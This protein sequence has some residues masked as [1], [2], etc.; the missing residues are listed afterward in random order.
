V[1][2]ITEE[3]IP[4]GLQQETGRE[5]FAGAGQVAMNVVMD[6]KGAVHRRPGISAFFASADRVVDETGISAVHQASNGQVYAVGNGPNVKAIYRV[7]PLG[8]S[9]LSH[10]MVA[11]ERPVIAETQSLLVLAGGQQL[12]KVTL[13]NGLGAFL[14]GSP[15]HSTHVA[16][17]ASR[18]VA[19][20]VSNQDLKNNFN[21]S[22]PQA[23]SGIAGYETWNG[24]GDSGTFPANA[25]PDA[26][27]GVYEK[28]NEL[29]IFGESNLQTFSPDPQT[30]WA[31]TA[32]REFGC[33]APYSVIKDDQ[34]FAWLDDK[35]RFVHSDGRTFQVISDAIKR[36]L[37]DMA[38]V[39]DCFGYRIVTGVTDVLVWTFPTDGRTFVFSKQSGWSQWSG[40]NQGWQP[41]SV[42]AMSN[43]LG[44]NRNLVGLLDGRMGIMNGEAT[45]DLGAEINA[46]M[47]TGFLDHGTQTRK[48]CRRVR[49]VLRKPVGTGQ[50]ARLSWRDDSGPW[51]QPL[52]ARLEDPNVVQFHSL[53]VYRQ[54]QW[55][56]EFMGTAEVVLA[57][58]I[59][60]F[61]VLNG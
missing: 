20:E 39:D 8:V 52:Y 45:T 55:R 29:F 16:A 7:T 42:L 9:R 14:G 60:E 27:V 26:I 11:T 24:V 41:F 1:S 23:G 54:R 6:G 13:S 19:R 38:V 48:H 37:D 33:S 10:S 15:P 2:Q 32:T 43:G 40:W 4:F 30:V 21:Y 17:I 3:R 47:T 50:V 35:R 46:F 25:R 22:A 12:S 31:P 53:G 58:A 61:E 49:L 36:V 44:S 59:E 56:F 57:Q 18:L 51:S 34:S 5:A 28:T